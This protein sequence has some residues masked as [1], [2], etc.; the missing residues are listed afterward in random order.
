MIITKENN[1]LVLR[2][3]IHQPAFDAAN[4]QVGEVDALI[5]VCTGSDYSIS[6]LCDMTYAGKAPQ[7]GM[8][9]IMFTDKEALLE[10]CKTLGIDVIEH[11]S[12]VIC[13]KPI[14]GSHTWNNGPICYNC[15]DDLTSP[16]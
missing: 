11:E 12:C 16:H 15:E 4:E 6:Y 5:G 9:V 7:E 10:A 1:E 2:I 8:P 13:K 3:P 14:Y